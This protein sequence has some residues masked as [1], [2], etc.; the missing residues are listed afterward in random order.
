MT[1]VMEFELSGLDAMD[2][3]GFL[4]AIGCLASLTDRAFEE[5]LPAPHLRWS[6]GSSPRPTVE[7]A[8]ESRHDLLRWLVDDL[9]ALAGRGP[10]ATGEDAFLS[11]S[12]ETKPGSLAHDLKP[13]PD[14]LRAEAARVLSESSPLCRRTLDWFAAAITDVAVDG[15]GNGKPFA[16]HFTAGQQQFLLV[17]RE[18]AH[19]AGTSGPVNSQALEEAL[20]GPW[21]NASPLKVFS[22]SPLQ[23]RAYALRAVDPSKDKKLGT[24]GADWLAF[25]GL[26]LFSSAPQGERIATCGVRGGWKS[27]TFSYPIWSSAMPADTVRALLRHPALGAELSGMDSRTATRRSLPSGVEILTCTI[28]RS[29][30][31]GYGAF[32]RPSRSKPDTA[33]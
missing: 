19:G 30:Q 22:W 25:R 5:D 1:P 12:Y 18:L 31:G 11:F 20:F 16:L 7:V 27:G 6:V 8:V 4:A 9:E 17:A 28:S 13:P 15:N 26:P 23:D 32:S 24:P 2:P 29:D 14:V 21:R 33:D 3:L 10:D